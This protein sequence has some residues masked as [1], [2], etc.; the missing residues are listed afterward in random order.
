[1]LLNIFTKILSCVSCG[2]EIV[3]SID[4]KISSGRLLRSLGGFGII[5]GGGGAIG[6]TTGSGAGSSRGTPLAGTCQT[7]SCHGSTARGRY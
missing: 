1:M 6:S 4:F 3:F 2:V 5:I 7:G